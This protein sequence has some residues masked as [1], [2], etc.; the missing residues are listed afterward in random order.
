MKAVT[1]ARYI[2]LHV[3]GYPTQEAFAAAL[4][5]TQA[6]ISRFEKGQQFSSEAQSRIRE[7]AAKKNIHWDNNLFFEVP[8]MAS[9]DNV[10]N[11]ANQSQ[12][13]AEEITA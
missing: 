5:F 6:H 9:A 10:S 12:A 3:F 4:G 1:P 8:V 13:R 2:R 11:A 7:L